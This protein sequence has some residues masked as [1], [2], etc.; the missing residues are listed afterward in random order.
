M[1]KYAILVD[2]GYV[3]SQI[4]HMTSNSDQ[5]L[6][7]LDLLKMRESLLE[8]SMGLFPS[9]EL[10]RI[11]WYDGDGDNSLNLTF[12]RGAVNSK[13]A[14][15]NNFKLRL[16]T[17]NSKRQQKGVD[18]LIIADLISLAQNRCVSDVL[19][20]SGDADLAP[21]VV[22][23]Q[24]LGIRVHQLEFGSKTATSPVLLREV[25][26][27]FSWPEKE[28]QTFIKLK[29]KSQFIKAQ[30]SSSTEK[31][32]PEE[33]SDDVFKNVLKLIPNFLSDF[34]KQQLNTLQINDKIPV[35]IDKKILSFISG[36]LKDTLSSEQVLYVRT[37]LKLNFDFEKVDNFFEGSLLTSEQICQAL[38]VLTP[39]EKRSISQISEGLPKEVDK[40][41]LKE[42]SRILGRP[43]SRQDKK[44]LRMKARSK[45]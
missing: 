5:L 7:S 25:D 6:M 45:D 19:L 16:G 11:Y 1:E 13:I 26:C 27:G 22:A 24:T 14:E 29:Q 39:A 35:E 40:K 10:F 12:N 30:I 36:A 33:F 18:G 8:K 43:L 44:A 34:D 37:F 23:A 42:A 3:W 20:V 4:Q 38:S 9:R 2:A 41:L 31:H 28:I 15:M 32:L 21:G 17:V